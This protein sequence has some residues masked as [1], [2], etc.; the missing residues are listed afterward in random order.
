MGSVMTDI[1]GID[2][3][4]TNSLIG[5]VEAGFPILLADETGARLTPS[6]VYFPP[7]GGEPA[8]GAAALRQRILSPE[9]TVVSVKRLIGRRPGELEYT[10]DYPTVRDTRGGLSVRIDDRVL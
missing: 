1:V 10:P 3:G 4:T 8:V 6:A 5:I 7:D 2:L 9:R